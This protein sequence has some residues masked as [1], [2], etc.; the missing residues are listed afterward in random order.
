MRDHVLQPP[1]AERRLELRA[2]EIGD[3]LA[4]HFLAAVPE[5]RRASG[6]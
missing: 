3:Q 2:H 1:A 5:L 6:R 4:E